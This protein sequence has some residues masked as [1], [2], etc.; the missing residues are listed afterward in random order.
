MSNSSTKE[1][2]ERLVKRNG[3]TIIDVAEEVTSQGYAVRGLRF[4]SAN[5]LN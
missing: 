4:G 5:I 2:I 3:L 1:D